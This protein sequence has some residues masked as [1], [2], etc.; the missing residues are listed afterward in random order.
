MGYDHAY[1]IK[2]AQFALESCTDQNRFEVLN[3]MI[4]I[5]RSIDEKATTT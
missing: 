1:M 3:T 4:H 5:V 2:Y